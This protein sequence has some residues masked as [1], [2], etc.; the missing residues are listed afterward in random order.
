[1]GGLGAFWEARNQYLEA[2]DALM[3]QVSEG[4][5]SL[6]A[7]QRQQ[8]ILMSFGADRAT[9]RA[10]TIQNRSQRPIYATVVALNVKIRQPRHPVAQETAY[11]YI[12]T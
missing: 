6:A 9:P 5:A 4:A 7:A 11:L 2:R 12:P 10:E 8:A 3:L 1:V